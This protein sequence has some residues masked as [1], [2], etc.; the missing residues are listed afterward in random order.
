[1][2]HGQKNIKTCRVCSQDNIKTY[3]TRKEMEKGL[4]PTPNEP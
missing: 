4:H 2:M 1:M 3:T